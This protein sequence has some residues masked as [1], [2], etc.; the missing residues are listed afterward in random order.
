M[1][2]FPAEMLTAEALS[3]IARGGPW[4]LVGAVSVCVFALSQAW[5]CF[6]WQSYCN[7]K[8]RSRPSRGAAVPFSHHF[9][10]GRS[11]RKGGLLLQLQSVCNYLTEDVPRIL[12]SPV[13]T[14]RLHIAKDCILQRV[15]K[16]L[17]PTA[18]EL[19]IMSQ[20]GRAERSR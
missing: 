7:R 19:E 16:D 17:G 6:A 10:T 1:T 13:K 15:A 12:L 11:D 2:C 14:L 20:W 3:S 5:A 4:R 9:T 8:R 18:E